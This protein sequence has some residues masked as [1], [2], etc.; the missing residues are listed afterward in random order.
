[1]PKNI[2]LTGQKDA[3]RSPCVFY[4]ESFKVKLT[5]AGMSR[6]G[7]WRIHRTAKLRRMRSAGET[8]NYQG[9]KMLLNYEKKNRS[10]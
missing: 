4:F 7:Y 5:L 10:Q 8:P 6:K 9:R 1:M 3:R 2:S